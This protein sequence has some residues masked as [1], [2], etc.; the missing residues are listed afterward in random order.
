M[1]REAATTLPQNF[2]PLIDME[3]LESLKTAN[4]E[5]IATSPNE[6][7]DAAAGFSADISQIS[8]SSPSSRRQQSIS[9]N[10][11]ASQSPTL[12]RSDKLGGSV[13]SAT[14]GTNNT[15]NNNNNNDSNDKNIPIYPPKP[16]PTPPKSLLVPIKR[17]ASAPSSRGGSEIMTRT[18][19]KELPVPFSV[20]PPSEITELKLDAPPDIVYTS[21]DEEEDPT[22]LAGSDGSSDEED[23]VE[24]SVT[25]RKRMGIGL[26]L[27]M[28]V[29][30]QSPPTQLE[31]ATNQKNSNNS[32]GEN[33]KEK[34]RVAA[35]RGTFAKSRR[36]KTERAN[37]T[38]K[39]SLMPA[40]MQFYAKE[41]GAATSA[42]LERDTR[43]GSK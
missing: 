42:L 30:P 5:D 15:N 39:K 2:Q 26:G 9:S 34:L 37:S 23:V 31:E 35:L 43:R 19:V 12:G 3:S 28:P 38:A 14:P 22:T 29:V 1:K 20:S 41:L 10:N 40:S 6:E 27:S 24:P 21:E 16:L 18:E 32:S 11:A 8:Y 36:K 33:V 25:P 4:L 17:G 13:T 7:D